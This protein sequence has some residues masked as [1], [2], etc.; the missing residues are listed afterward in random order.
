MNKPLLI[1]VSLIL[2]TCMVEAA[3]PSKTTSSTTTEG[4][5]PGGGTATTEGT[6]PDNTKINKRDRDARTVTPM[7]QANNQVDLDITQAIRKSIMKQELSTNA[8]NIKIITQNGEVT[9][10]GPVNSDAEAEK[11][12]QLAKAVPS[13]KTLHNQLEVK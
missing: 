9:L 5:T 11:I 2:V 1:A 7:D 8:K 6:L 10:R 4:V 12:I 13:V 3:E